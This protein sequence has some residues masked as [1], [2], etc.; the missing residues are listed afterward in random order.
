MAQPGKQVGHGSDDGPGPIAILVVGRMD[1]NTHQQ[2]GSVGHDMALSAFGFLGRIPRGPPLSVIS[3][4][5]LS[6]TPAEGL[7]SRPAASP[8]CST[9]SKLIRSYKPWSRQS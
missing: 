4:D 8:A 6:M 9:S 3:T 5:W 2:A 7:G 1:H